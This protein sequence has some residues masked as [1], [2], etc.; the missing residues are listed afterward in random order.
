M[1][2][3]INYFPNVDDPTPS[4]AVLSPFDPNASTGPVQTWDQQWRVGCCSDVN[5]IGYGIYLQ[6]DT[7]KRNQGNA[8]V[9]VIQHIPVP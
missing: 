5:T 1:V 6:S 4:P 9:S 3:H 8:R 7:L 2:D